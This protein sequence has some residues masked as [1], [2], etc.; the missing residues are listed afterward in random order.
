MREVILVGGGLSGSLL[1]LML[2]RRGLKVTV[3]E[4]REDV[5][6]EKIEEGRSINLA[7]SVR[8]IH[9]LKQVGLA[10]EVLAQTIPMRGRF[11]HPVS[12]PTSLIPYGRKS[13]EVIHSVSRRG[14]NV[15]LLDALAKEQN[16]AV[17][18][19]HRCTG[20][21]LRTRTLTIRD[22]SAGREFGV[23]GPVV[24]GTDG[25]ASAVRLSLMLHTR[26]N[27][28]QEYL[29]HGY[30]ELTI[31]PAAVGS[32]RIEPNALHIWPRGGFMMIA[33][34]NMDRSFTCTLFLAH[35]E[36]EP[37]AASRDV[38]GF[39][40]STFPD[41]IPLLP[42]L[43]E[44]FFHNPTGGLVTV[45]CAPWHVGGQVLLLGDAAHAIVPFF[46][47]GMNCAFEDCEVLMELFDA[48]GGDWGEVFPRFFAAR[49]PNTD[50]IAQLAL[51]NF[52]EMRDTSADPHFALKRQLE[53]VLEERYPGQFVSK[54]GMVSFHRVPYAEALTRGRVQDRVLMEVCARANSLAE[55][56]VA[57]VFARLQGERGA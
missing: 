54:Y 25:A 16:V 41:A 11:I 38:T 53:H 49:K 15:Q 45:R 7:L 34:P 27:Y 57:A 2:A 5:R 50:A 13:D 4:R 26:M 46:G 40:A 52:I 10:A 35:R 18:F 36:F 24:I 23:Q 37:L 55:I 44:D 42:D 9:A 6:V 39:F 14:L 19:H 8:G 31:P 30:K 22:E 28:A 33:L 21:D 32:F 56:D 17:H 12:G 1:A 43:E 48:H 3:Y 29:E 20:Y 47:Q 51:D